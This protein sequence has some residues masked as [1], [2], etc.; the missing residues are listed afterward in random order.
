MIGTVKWFKSDKGYGFIESR[1]C[2]SDVFVH[3]TSI[4]MDGFRFLNQGDKV[5][6]NVERNDRGLYA[7]DVRKE[8]KN[9]E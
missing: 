4:V 2:E 6:F 1:E 5:S 3:H 9:H 8:E 7:V